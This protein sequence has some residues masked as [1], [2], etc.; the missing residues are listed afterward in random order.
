MFYS[1]LEDQT[2]IEEVQYHQAQS[3]EF[4]E[5]ANSPD[6]NP[7]YFSL[8]EIEFTGTVLD[9]FII[10]V[11]CPELTSVGEN[12]YPKCRQLADDAGGRSINAFRTPSARRSGG[13]CTPVFDRPSLGDVPRL[14]R[15]GRF[16]SEHG[17]IVFTEP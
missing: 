6:A 17:Q 9:L 1:A 14:R 7:R 13:T 5:L 10:H 3:G 12:G 4:N 2:S 8:F 16:T 11:D 15:H